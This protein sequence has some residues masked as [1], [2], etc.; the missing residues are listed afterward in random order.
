MTVAAIILAAGKSTRMKSDSPK[1]LHEICGR[2]MLAYVLTACRLAG[3]EKLVVVVGHGRSQVMEAFGADKDITWVHQTEQ[4]G[5]GHAVICCKD[6]MADVEGSVLVIAGDMPLVR[7]EALAELLGERE[8]TG[9]A[10]TIATTELDDPT[11]YGRIIRDGEGKLQ[12]IAEHRDCNEEQRA[13]HEVNPSYYCFDAKK[14]FAALDRVT[15]AS[16]SGEFYITDAIHILREQGERV[17]AHVMVPAEDALGINS[18]LDLADVS[19]VMQDRIQVALLSGGVTIVDPDN[20]WIEADATVGRDTVIYPFSFIG[21]GAVIGSDCRIG[22]FGLVQADETV[23]AG[24]TVG[25]SAPEFA[26]V[27][28]QVMPGAMA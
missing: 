27:T 5:T 24:A 12:A 16:G 25:P 3:I 2:P 6:A 7:R 26:R 11:G 17:S 9:D 4:K 13:I 10:L 8:E 22:P 23:A 19:R 14:M 20:T 18:R 28:R 21:A 1:V 15:P